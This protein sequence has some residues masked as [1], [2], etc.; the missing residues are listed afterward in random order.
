MAETPPS[1]SSPPSGLTTHWCYN[2]TSH[3]SVENPSP[4]LP[5][6]VCRSCKSGFVVESAPSSSS[7]AAA[8]TTP[9]QDSSSFD[10]DYVQLLRLVARSRGEAPPAADASM[11]PLRPSEDNGNDDGDDDDDDDF[12][13][14]EFDGWGNEADSGDEE[15]EA[16]YFDEMESDHGRDGEQQ[17]Q[18]SGDLFGRRVRDFISRMGAGRR[19]PLLDWAEIIRGL[20][21]HI[22]ELRVEMPDE[23][24]GYFGN[25]EDYV[26]A[27]G[28]EVLLQNLM[29]ND[30]GARRGAPPAARSAVARLPTVVIGEDEGLMCAICKET[31]RAGE[32]G[33]KLP[34]E[35]VYHGACIVPWLESRNS[36]PV[37][38][39]ELP[40]D[41]V[42][43][44]EG[45]KTR[46][47]FT[48]NNAI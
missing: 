4:D 24:D 2:C 20:E 32:E 28:Y 1:S 13:R 33:K 43:Y 17:P 30:G 39:F 6:V 37:C 47:D 21:D 23:S 18:R 8:P 10:S 15:Y 35:H 11:P 9:P 25:P 42:E 12:L 26:D 3:V 45:R 48:R 22:I 5:D 19:S 34:C 14:I 29:E 16:D 40:T 7:A 41:D 36:C 46:P 31:M 38:R 27:A 44:E